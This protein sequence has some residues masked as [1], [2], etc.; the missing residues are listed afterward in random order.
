M[1][2]FTDKIPEFNPYV[3]QLPVEAMVKVGMEKQRRYDEGIQK[4]Q[5][6]IDQ[7][8][9]LDVVRDVDRAYLQ[10]KINT[11]GNNL[12]GFM[13]ADF[14][15]YQMVNTVSGMTGQVA[16]DQNV[17]NAVI[18]TAKFRK[19]TEVMEAAK[20]AGKSSVQNE[21]FF[22]HEANEW[23]SSPELK[24]KYTGAYVEY[25]DID[26]KLRDVADKVHEL[27]N[28]IDIPYKRDNAGNVIVGPGGKPI[29]DDAMLR[30]KTKGKPAEKLLSN[31]YSSLNENDQRQLHID[32][33]YHY[34]S[35]TPDTFKRDVITNYNDQRKML[36]DGI[37]NMNAELL[38]NPNLSTAQKGAIQA[39]IND[40]HTLLS[41]GTLE[42]NLNNQLAQIDK[43]NIEEY[44]YKIYT[45]KYLTDLANN[46]SYQSIQQSYET[47][48]Y[49][50]ADMEKRR[51]QFSYDN[52]NR[53]Q[54]N[55]EKT[56]GFNT[57]KFQVETSM[58]QAE[59]NLKAQEA[60][61][62]QPIVT[63]SR[64]STNINPPSLIDVNKDI[65]GIKENLAELNKQYA[66]LLTNATLNTP[67][68]KKAYL[69]DIAK[70]YST[71]PGYLSKVKD[72]NLKDYLEQRRLLEIQLG[73]KNNLYT[74]TVNAS[75][76]YVEKINKVFKTAG[77]IVDKNGRNLYS[78][79]EL[80][81]FAITSKTFEETASAGGTVAKALDIEGLIKKYKGTRFE[82]LAQA[83]V[84]EYMGTGTM[85]STDKTLML[86][87]KQVFNDFYGAV[88]TLAN[89][90]FKFQTDFL[91]TKMPE[92]QTA[93]GALSKDNKIDMDHVDQLIN[94]KREEYSQG[95]LDTS[96]LRDFNPDT[97]EALRKDP[98]K[99]VGYVIEKKYDGTA[100]LI[101]SSGM[102]RQTI[103][104]TQEEFAAYFPNYARKN[105]INDIKYAVLASPNKTTNLQGGKGASGAV[106]AYLSGYDLPNIPKQ[107]A[108]M[109]R[110]D[111]EGRPFN[112][113]SSN[114]RY[115]VRMYVNDG[116]QWKTDIIGGY[117]TE[118][119]LKE[120]FNQIG[121]ATI[122]DFLQ[123]TK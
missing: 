28:S 55:F 24:S 43:G 120:T 95:G 40:D 49:F 80:Y 117:V 31:F 97:V 2:S 103:P 18:S 85:S 110:I 64:I 87:T 109:V 89:Q 63:A 45:Q 51:L 50:Q 38:T 83:R 76:V 114:D 68:K 42:Q 90:K 34:R 75:K 69:D 17:Q 81:E 36:S 22:T 19:E 41:N 101:I 82:P 8:A 93:I 78:A 106:N 5:S 33:W 73:Q 118:A 30:I 29:I 86:K 44:K 115:Q 14:S 12:K 23:L 57:Y 74:T 71:D 32:S 88:N 121:T 4:I 100:N 119:G 98:K 77:G 21:T 16:K 48:P 52:A 66:P 54:S 25:T 58:K 39:K 105:P 46:M 47:N 92:R 62:S 11:L 123:K 96:A 99:N 84:K 27:D 67:E 13:A 61:G 116:T 112:D 6:N 56:F 122:Q 79:K 9:G 91:A 60:L 35:A 53:E 111:V 59:L 104:L 70:N 26:K 10:S 20:R 94:R 72:N 15:D 37:V 7:I 102:A 3:A 1:A 65:Q 113:G 107:L 108:P